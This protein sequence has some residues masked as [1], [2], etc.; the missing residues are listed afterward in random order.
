MEIL[1]SKK[2]TKSS[3]SSTSQQ[4]VDVAEVKDDA[5]VLKN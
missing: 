3:S 5:I 1:N 4:F 2:I